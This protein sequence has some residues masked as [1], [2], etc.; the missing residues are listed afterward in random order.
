LAQ[1]PADDSEIGNVSADA[2]AL[3]A[4]VEELRRRLAAL[5]ERLP[6]SA[7][8]DPPKRRQAIRQPRPQSKTETA[9]RE[10]D[11][12]ARLARRRALGLGALASLFAF[13]GRSTARA[14]DALTI[15]PDGATIYAKYIN[16]GNRFGALLRLWDPGYE[17]GIQPATV[18]ARSDKN[19]AWYKGG[20]YLQQELAPG[21]DGTTM[22]S[23]SDGNLAVSGNVTAGGQFVGKETTTLEKGLTVAGDATLQKSLAVAGPMKIDGKNALEFGAG[24]TK[25]TN[26]G[27][28]AYQ[29]HSGD[30]LDIVGAGTDGTNRK[31]KFWAEG[32][33]TLN[34]SLNL[35]GVV[36]G[37]VKVVYQKGDEVQTT[38]QKPLWRYHMSLTLGPNGQQRTKTIPR[39]VLEALCGKGDGCEVRLGMRRWDN[40]NQTETLP[41][42]FLFYLNPQDGHWMTSAPLE[43]G[44][45]QDARAGVIGNGTIDAEDVHSVCYFRQADKDISM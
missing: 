29:K 6:R 3:L 1:R 11:T 41:I 30:A 2:P 37:N 19:F 15:E 33:A 4:E 17:F 9:E 21:G 40:D 20:T 23:L 5:E 36:D 25:E 39:E 16:F 10:P 24:I 13:I 28:I 43:V 45:G 38:Y 34:G 26:A 35:S 7:V 42:V 27:Q 12:A 14:A 32:G 22:M 44:H 8:A 31:I 18:Y